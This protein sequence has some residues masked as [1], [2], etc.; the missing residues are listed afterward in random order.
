MLENGERQIEREPRDLE[1]RR[2][3][4]RDDHRIPHR[5]RSSEVP[6]P[7]APIREPALDLKAEH[8][9]PTRQFD[10][11]LEQ[12]FGAGQVAAAERDPAQRGGRE[13]GARSA[14]G[15]RQ[16][17]DRGLGSVEIA[18]EQLRVRREV[19]LNAPLSGSDRDQTGDAADHGP[20]WTVERQ[21]DDRAHRREHRGD[22]SFQS[23]RAELA[24]LA[25]TRIDHHDLARPRLSR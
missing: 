12:L 13:D 6:T 11:A 8:V 23:A 10:H 21:P 5:A 19:R 22:R 3:A 24:E 16:R 17:V 2:A 4:L 18:A 25:S 14:C 1:D 20:E 7:R 15:R 9:V